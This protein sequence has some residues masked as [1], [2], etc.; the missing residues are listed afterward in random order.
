MRHFTISMMFAFIILSI[1]QL[2]PVGNFSTSLCIFFGKFF[3]QLFS[4]TVLLSTC[5]DEINN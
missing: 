5:L 2:T 1:N 3:S 4:E